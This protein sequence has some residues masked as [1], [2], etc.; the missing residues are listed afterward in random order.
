MKNSN[1]FIALATCFFMY[2]CGTTDSDAPTFC[3][4]ADDV[5]NVD[6]VE[7]MAGTTLTL[8]Q[9]VC[10]N[11]AL[12]TANWDI[13]SAEGHAH[14]GEEEEGFVLF[15]GSW[16]YDFSDELTGTTETSG[17][18]TDIPNNVRG[19]WDI[20]ISLVDNEGNI[21]TDVVTPLH[22]ENDYIPEYQ[23]TTV[24]GLDLAVGGEPV[25]EPGATITIEGTLTDSD[26]IEHW[27]YHLENEDTE[28]EIAEDEGDGAGNTEVAFTWTIEIPS[29]AT[30][31]EYHFHMHAD[32]MLENSMETGFHVEIE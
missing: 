5:A 6:E 20:V 29:D 32:D 31:G 11:E 26:G 22:I 12:G 13:H 21:A 8:N 16:D 10:D 24:T 25:W 1:L 23:L 7:A 14:E 17:I 28:V 19:V 9:T 27:G 3:S 30:P 2:S 15:S 18:S 4:V